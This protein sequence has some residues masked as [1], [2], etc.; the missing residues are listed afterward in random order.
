[1]TS[2]QFDCDV[3]EKQVFPDHDNR[4][5]TAWRRTKDRQLYFGI[6]QKKTLKRHD[7]KK[8]NKTHSHT[9]MRRQN[10]S[11]FWVFIS[12]LLWL[13]S[14]LFEK[15]DPEF[16][17]DMELNLVFAPKKE[18]DRIQYARQWTDYVCA[19]FWMKNF[20]LQAKKDGRFFI[21]LFEIFGKPIF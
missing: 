2:R 5:Q 14:P 3:K 13:L 17:I 16:N 8:R 1:M 7:W 19:F 20:P 12:R 10:N 11:V 21:Y 18:T 6:E 9:T 15:K 4:Y